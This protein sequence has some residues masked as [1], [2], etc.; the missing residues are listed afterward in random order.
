MA[1]AIAYLFLYRLSH[2]ARVSLEKRLANSPNWTLSPSWLRFRILR[3]H[4]RGVF[5]V[6]I[7]KSET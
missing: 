6:S 4:R 2:A 1:L 7:R 5:R 3:P